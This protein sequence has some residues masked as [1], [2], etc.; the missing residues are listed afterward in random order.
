MSSKASPA[1][2]G[3]FVVGA[4]AL[5]VAALL[6][7]GSGRFFAASQDFA[8]FFQG[9][10]NGLNPGAAVRF[11]GVR[12]G[13]VREIRALGVPESGAIQIAVVLTLEEGRVRPLGSD[14]AAGPLSRNLEEA[15][16]FLIEEHGLR[17]QLG[18]DSMVTGQLY[19]NLDFFPGTEVRRLGLLP[20]YPELPAVPSDLQEIRNTLEGLA[21]RVRAL[22]LEELVQ[23][24]HTTLEGASRLVNGPATARVVERAD[25]TLAEASRAMRDARVLIE[26]VEGEVEPLSRDLRGVLVRLDD[27]LDRLGEALATFE[28]AT[29]RDSEV[30][31]AMTQALVELGA[32]ARSVRALADTLER[33]PSAVVFGRPQREEP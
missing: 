5:A 1:A 33:N 27:T 29:G 22:P 32:A 20:E 21:A 12:V 13:Q 11:R 19:V 17:A 25:A 6:V 14:S 2:I 4:I 8:T 31:L 10:V 16:E 18:V 26:K 23:E 24:L 15:V 3:A 7:F 9:S 28:T 30:R